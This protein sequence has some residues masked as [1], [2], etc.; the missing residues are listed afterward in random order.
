MPS[1]TDDANQRK[2]GGGG[3]DGGDEEE[4]ANFQEIEMEIKATTNDLSENLLLSDF[5]AE[6]EKLSRSLKGAHENEMRIE[7][8]CNAL[9][10]DTIA[11][12]EKAKNDSIE[13]DELHERKLH[14]T[15]EIEVAWKG[16]KTAHEKS[17]ERKKKV[18]VIR[19]RNDA[20]LE[21][22]ELGSGWTAEQKST[23]NNLNRKEVELITKNKKEFKILESIR[24]EIKN[25]LL[26]VQEEEEKRNVVESELVIMISKIDAVEKKTLSE[27]LNYS[28]LTNT[29]DEKRLQVETESNNLKRLQQKV[30]DG[31]DGIHQLE[32]KL[33]S[34]KKQMEGYLEL[35]DTLFHE[36]KNTTF[37]LDGQMSKNIN[38]TNLIQEIKEK[39]KNKKDDSIIIQKKIV[40]VLKLIQVGKKRLSSIEK[41]FVK[42]EKKR[43]ALVNDI[44]T[45]QSDKERSKKEVDTIKSNSDALVREKLILTSDSTK[46]MDRISKINLIY[47]INNNG[48]KNYEIEISSFITQARTQ[49]EII[50]KLELEV[51][52]YNEESKSMY[53]KYYTTLE[54]VKYNNIKIVE[55]QK[56]ILESNSRL[57][58]QQNL[59]EQVRSERNL[60]SKNLVEAK[61]NITT[62]KVLFS[63][64]NH[65]INQMKD[66]ITIKDHS[67][68]K[69]H[70]DHHKVEKRKI[71]I[72]NELTK[73]RKQIESSSQIQ[74]SQLIEISKLNHIIQEAEEE[75]QRQKKEL[76]AVLGER[77]ILTSQLVSRGSELDAIYKKIKIQRTYL[78]QGEKYFNEVMLK[79]KNMN[80]VLSNLF[81]TYNDIQTDSS[82]LPLLK[83]KAYLLET[84]LFHEKSKVKALKDE[85]EKMLNVHRWRKLQDSQPNVHAKILRV[86]ELQKILIK[87][88]ELVVQKDLI[89]QDKERLYVELKNVL[90]RQPGPEVAEQLEIYGK[91]HSFFCFHFLLLLLT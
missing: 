44:A 60:Y 12:R 73:I 58:Q 29:L 71:Q 10:N 47:K 40:K 51:T 84:E 42:S 13:Q 64:M 62:M 76:N 6:Y 24:S 67:L 91:P 9:V 32:Q 14:L 80:V 57:K 36:S 87:K 75:R 68:V 54:N 72:K 2:Q 66:E 20:L 39:I 25:I 34:A 26:S 56:K 3:D 83:R 30:K 18:L 43:D 52:K 35:Y 85:S 69:E 61:N 31:N 82:E 55:I 33:M 22:I 21:K 90:A 78:Q 63:R 65:D 70:F 19:K 37:S 1:V 46:V 49:R 41:L 77:D 79:E 28:A 48:R 45:L 53:N 5:K 74:S 86:H 50:E 7:K 88:T 89:I 8:K 15:K 11:I 16:V 17:T 81:K 27:Q 4:D 59:Y 38:E 23:M